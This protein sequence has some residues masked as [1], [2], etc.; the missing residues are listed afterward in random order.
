MFKRCMVILVEIFNGLRKTAYFLTSTVS[1][2]NL[3]IK[4]CF[5]SLITIL[6]IFLANA[7]ESNKMETNLAGV[8]QEKILFIQNPYNR[9]TKEFCIDEVHINGRRLDM[10]YNLSALKLDFDGFDSYTPVKIKVLH[11]DSLCTPIIIN[12]EAVLFHTIFRFVEISLSDSS[13]YWYTK[14]EKGVGKF[15]VERLYNGIWIDQEIMEA[16]GK[17]EGQAYIHYPNLEEG[18]NK[19]RV[20]YNFPPG[21]RI[22]HLYSQEIEFEF[23]PERVEFKPKSAKTRLYL[24]RATHY[25]IYDKGNTLVLEGQGSEIDVTVLRRGNYVIYFNGR[26]PGSFIKE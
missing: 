13:L 12:P 2:T 16:T 15:E 7:Q 21:S 9:S 23:Y 4:R 6:I 24:S 8:Y 18:S 25:E 3:M 11:K 10:N 14:G 19:Y 20:R 5:S 1:N 26:D 17:Y 22:S